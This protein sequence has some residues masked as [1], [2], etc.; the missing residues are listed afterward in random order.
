MK[1]PR[2][3][4][5]QNPFTLRRRFIGKDGKPGEWENKG[6]GEFTDISTV[7]RSIM[8]LK[9]NYPHKAMDIEFIHDGK[10][11]DFNGKEIKG[12]IEYRR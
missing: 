2:Q 12:P 1:R 11:K 9:A 5:I 10:F 3:T 8:V 7:Q 6:T 4:K